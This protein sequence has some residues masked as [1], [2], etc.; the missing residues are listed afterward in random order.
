MNVR[1]EFGDRF[2]EAQAKGTGIVRVHAGSRI[3]DIRLVELDDLR[4]QNAKLGSEVFCERNMMV[5]TRF[6]EEFISAVLLDLARRGAF[7]EGNEQY[8]ASKPETPH[9]MNVVNSSLT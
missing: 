8:V 5:V 4:Y 2:F 1:I 3:F 6:D 9:P 7:D